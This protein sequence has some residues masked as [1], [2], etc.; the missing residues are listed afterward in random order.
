MIEKY[1]IQLL[2]IW[3]ICVRGSVQLQKTL[4]HLQFRSVIF[5]DVTFLSHLVWLKSIE[6]FGIIRYQKRYYVVYRTIASNLSIY[7][8]L[9][10]FF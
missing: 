4:Q 2:M 6:L 5:D 7:Q 8:S 3:N 9:V 1:F 10:I